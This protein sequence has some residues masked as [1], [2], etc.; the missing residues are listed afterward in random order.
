MVFW[1][2]WCQ[3]NSHIKIKK[4]R[5]TNFQNKCPTHIGSSY[6]LRS[7]QVSNSNHAASPSRM[8]RQASTMASSTSNPALALTP[9]SVL[10]RPPLMARLMGLAVGWRFSGLKAWDDEKMEHTTERWV[11]LSK[12]EYNIR[13]V[14]WCLWRLKIG[15]WMWLVWCG[16][17]T[18]CLCSSNSFEHKRRSP[19]FPCSTA[20]LSHRL[21]G[22]GRSNPL[23]KAFQLDEKV[24]D[25]RTNVFYNVEIHIGKWW[26]MQTSTNL[27]SHS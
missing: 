27:K 12:H 8:P 14:E 26:K 4:A 2:R 11:W 22:T 16:H 9:P 23:L 24:K 18:C 15:D 10:K 17:W 3:F 5:I 21:A 19:L 20:S 1:C 7:G 13:I 25:S 6:H